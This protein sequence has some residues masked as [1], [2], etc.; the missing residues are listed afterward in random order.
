MKE[1]VITAQTLFN[2]YVTNAVKMRRQSA[3]GVA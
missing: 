3:A 2:F 1:K